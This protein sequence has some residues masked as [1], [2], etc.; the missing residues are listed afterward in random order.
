MTR[1]LTDVD[2]HH[3]HYQ[4]DLN[5]ELLR[6]VQKEI[7]TFPEVWK[8]KV[9]F[10]Q[11]DEGC[12]GTAASFAGRTALIEG[13]TP[14][15]SEDGCGKWVE[16]DGRQDYRD[17]RQD[18]VDGRQDY[19]DGRQDY[20]DGRQDYVDEV[21]QNALGLTPRQACTLFAARNSLD[22]IDRLVDEFCEGQ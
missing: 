22:D 17:G 4:S 16:R 1:S 12:C 15:S 5:V 3:I 13:W 11:K 14:V 9:W 8:Q 19:V 2:P 21:A 20:V 10:Q 6:R 7:H 18:Y